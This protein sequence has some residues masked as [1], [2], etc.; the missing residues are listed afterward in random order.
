MHTKYAI[1]AAALL[2]AGTAWAG[3]AHAAGS[4][5]SREATALNG[6]Q[7]TLSQA[8]A[9]AEAATHGRAFDAGVDFDK[10]KPRIT[11]ETNGPDG[12]QTVIVDAQSGRLLS[13]RAGGETD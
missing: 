3:T 12:V 11:V 2:L 10:S 6:S 4:D 13:T 5:E 9:Q 8:I 1:I 7:V